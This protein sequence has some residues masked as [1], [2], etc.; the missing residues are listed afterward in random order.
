MIPVG[1]LGKQ[2]DHCHRRLGTRSWDRQISDERS[3]A[4]RSLRKPLRALR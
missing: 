1:E 4:L 3:S 2:T